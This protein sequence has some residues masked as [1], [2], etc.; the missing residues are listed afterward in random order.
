MSHGFIEP[1][2]TKH[3]LRSKLLRW[4]KRGS[5]RGLVVAYSFLGSFVGWFVPE[6]SQSRPK[7]IPK[8]FQNRSKSPPNPPRAPEG[9]QGAHKGLPRGPQEAA[10]RAP[11]AP[12]ERSKRPQERPK[13]AQVGHRRP[14]K[15]CRKAFGDHF[16]DCKL[17]NSASRRRSVARLAQEAFWGAF[18]ADFSFVRASVEPHFDSPI[19]SRN[20]V[21]L[22]CE[23][24]DPLKRRKT[25]KALKSPLWGT[26]NRPKTTKIAFRSTLGI[27][28][29]GQ[30]DRRCLFER[31]WID[32]VGR[33]GPS[34]R[35]ARRLCSTGW[36]DRAARASSS[37][38][39]VG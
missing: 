37:V 3:S 33:K 22:F 27:G 36:L 10:K 24:V 20:E 7:I 15:T 14:P 30:I 19:P 2:K 6:S 38:G 23:R 9:L 11:S 35:L 13:S 18:F 26:K 29:G 32:L 34:E 28:S 4:E 12:Q 25:A 1:C 5:C 21:R 8:S 17:E 16:E 31:S 39:I